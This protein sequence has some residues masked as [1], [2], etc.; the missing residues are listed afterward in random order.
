MPGRRTCP[1]S[2]C[3]RSAAEGP[4]WV[5]PR[6]SPSQESDAGAR[7]TGRFAHRRRRLRPAGVIFNAVFGP[8]V[9]ATPD[10]AALVVVAVN[11]AAGGPRADGD[12]PRGRA[13]L[14]RMLDSMGRDARPAR[15]RASGPARR[16]HACGAGRAR[17]AADRG[18]L[19]PLGGPRDPPDRG[20]LAGR[21]WRARRRRA[22]RGERDLVL[23]LLISTAADP[24]R[25]G[26]H[27]RAAGTV[28]VPRRTGAA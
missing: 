3:S 16:R 21:E 6:R 9:A 24:L 23:V 8:L 28:V 17:R 26:L 1:G 4:S 2:R 5:G 7:R 11:P 10:G 25:R 12:A 22:G 20:W 27:D 19:A 13:L 15:A 18:G 14:R